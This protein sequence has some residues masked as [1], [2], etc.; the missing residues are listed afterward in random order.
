QGRPRTMGLL[1]TRA[2]N[3]VRYSLMN[4][5]VLIGAA[6]IAV[7]GPWT[8]TGLLLSF[9]LIGYVDELLGDAG[10]RELMPP[11]WYMQLMLY[12]TLPLLVLITLVVFNTT[13]ANGFGFL[14][15][16]FR[17]FGFDPEAARA[18]NGWWSGAG[19]YV[20]LGMFYGMAGVN[21][22]HELIH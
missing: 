11:V 14:D 12:L 17:F 9:V 19:A 5:F 4:I 13:T 16:L 3:T 21:V 8:W 2:A 20:S 1:A 15:A 22:A 18:R 6:A 10:D 7:G